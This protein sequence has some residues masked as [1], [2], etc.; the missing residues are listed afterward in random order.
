MNRDNLQTPQDPVNVGLDEVKVNGEASINLYPN[1]AASST[2]LNYNLEVAS[3]VVMNIYDMN[4]RL[5]STLDKGTQSAGS[6]S[7]IIDLRSMD[8]GV[9]MI[10]ML[11]KGSVNTVKL[12]VQ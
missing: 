8:K 10:Q 6:H 4:G 11:T 12:I 2:T 1:P 3:N 9:Y 7:Q 5:I